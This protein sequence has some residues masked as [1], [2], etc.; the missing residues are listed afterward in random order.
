MLQQATLNISKHRQ[1]LSLARYEAKAKDLHIISL[2]DAERDLQ[3]LCSAMQEKAAKDEATIVELTGRLE[4]LTTEGEG[5]ETVADLM[6]R[7]ERLEE[8]GVSKDA[9]IISLTKKGEEWNAN[10]TSLEERV[11][12]QETTVLQLT[13]M[14]KTQNKHSDTLSETVENQKK[15]LAESYTMIDQLNT[16]LQEKNLHKRHYGRSHLIAIPEMREPHKHL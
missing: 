5:G 7:L 10:A 4:N 13:E 8:E 9:Q 3:A 2:S 15:L 14:L 6:E 12:V 1:E 16:K 11:T